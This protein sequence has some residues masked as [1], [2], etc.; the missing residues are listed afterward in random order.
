M[1][2]STLPWYR[3]QIVVAALVSILTKLLVGFGVIG[4][5]AP[6]VNEELASTLVLVIGGIA[7]LVAIRSRVTQKA[8]P[9]ITAK[10]Q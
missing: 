4:E 3:S 1:Y 9:S 2:P 10:Q 6:E 5:I 7:D 8:A